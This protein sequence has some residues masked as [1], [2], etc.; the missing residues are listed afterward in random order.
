MK[1]IYLIRHGE[2]DFNKLGISQGSELDSELNSNGRTQSLFTGKYLNDYQE[3]YNVDCIMTSSMKR[4]KETAKII[5]NEIKFNGEIIAFHELKEIGKGKISGLPKDHLLKFNMKKCVKEKI[6]EFKDPIKI[7]EFDMEKHLNDT[8]GLE[9][10]TR[11]EIRVRARNI[12]Y[13]IENSSCKKILIISHFGILSSLLHEMLNINSSLVGNLKN[14]SNCWISYVKLINS[15]Y[16]L[17]SPPD[18]QHLT[19]YK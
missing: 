8:L 7:Y 1:E 5:A 10:E 2:T 6:S 3:G 14:G 9:M 16:H 18:S 19:I 4:A 17:I 12:M 15:S 13:Y 11:E